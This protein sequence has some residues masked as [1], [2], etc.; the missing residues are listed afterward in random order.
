MPTKGLQEVVS[1]VS[2]LLALLVLTMH[3]LA[4]ILCFHSSRI[5]MHIE[6]F[7]SRLLCVSLRFWK[8]DRCEHQIVFKSC[9]VNNTESA[10][11]KAESQTC[12]SMYKGECFSAEHGQLVQITG[13]QQVGMQQIEAGHF[14][15]QLQHFQEH[16]SMA[17]WFCTDN[18]LGVF[19]HHF[20]KEKF[21]S[22]VDEVVVNTVQF[23]T[24]LP[25]S[26][27]FKACQPRSSLVGHST[28]C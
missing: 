4:H 16:R 1:P 19:Q 24:S 12:S 9:C 15:L 5:F 7:R 11:K 28:V 20:P 25:G 10:S 3:C 21:I 22:Q 6:C 14:T 8:Q 26:E 18:K 2:S 13:G 17:P 23:E 27:C